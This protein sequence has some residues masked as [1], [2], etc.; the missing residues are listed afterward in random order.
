MSHLRIITLLSAAALLSVGSCASIAQTYPSKSIRVVAA[1][2]GGSSDFTARLMAHGLSNALGQ[3]VVVDN[4]GGH[5]II[6]GEIVSK[7]TPDG[8]TLLIYT[9]NL[10]ISPMLSGK[11]SYD[12]VRDFVPITLASR[13]PNVLVVN[14][15]SPAKSVKDL[16]DMAKAHPG[17]INFATGSFGSASHLSG[18]LFKNMAHIDIV[19]VPYK[20]SAPAL[21]DLMANRVQLMFPSAASVTPH[22]KAGQFKALAVTSATPSSLT[23]GMPTVSASGLPGFE[24][25]AIF[26]VWAPARTS[27]AIVQ[28]I[29]RESVRYLS[30]PE[31]RDKFFNG[32]VEVVASTPQELAQA[33]KSEMTRLGKMIKETGL[34]ES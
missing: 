1:E 23:P 16:I 7:A 13:A 14:P 30:L 15:S 24:I 25:V 29:Y 34:H 31:T 4:R 33:M 10:W 27:D 32:G 12:P 19:H 21:I 20:G 22:L 18:V 11:T 8:Y 3:Q 28:R 9:G 6:P 2:P 17:D 5:G 26:G